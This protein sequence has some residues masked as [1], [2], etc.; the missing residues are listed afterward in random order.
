M[1]E[2]R[3]DDT[4]MPSTLPTDH[5]LGFSPMENARTNLCTPCPYDK[6]LLVNPITTTAL[7]ITQ[8]VLPVWATRYA[9]EIQNLPWFQF[10]TLVPHLGT[11][12]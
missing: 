10:H 11:F 6:S 5:G 9:I 8:A 12:V 2:F 3:L 1:P 7:Q 4:D